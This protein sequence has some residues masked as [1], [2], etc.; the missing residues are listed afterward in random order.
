MRNE[1]LSKESTRNNISILYEMSFGTKR[2]SLDF[3]LY[4]R[5]TK[6]SLKSNRNPSIS[7]RFA[8]SPEV[9]AKSRY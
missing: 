4:S 2:N 8:V 6:C 7:I 1:K 5:N 3:V 9:V